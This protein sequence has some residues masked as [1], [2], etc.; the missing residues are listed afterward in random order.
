MLSAK[1][2]R[3]SLLATLWFN[4]AHYAVRPWPWILVARASLILLPGLKDPETGY[5][6]VMIDYLP[7]SLRGLMVAAFAAAFMSTIA[8]QLNWGA[9]YLVNDFYRR[10]VRRDAGEP[11]YVLA[12]RLAT[13]LLTVISAAVAF[14]IESI[15]CAW[16]LLII[17]GAGTGAVLLLRWYWWRINA[18]SEVSAM[19]TAFIVSVLLQTVGR[20]PGQ[21]A[22]LDRRLRARVRGAVRRGQAAV[23]RPTARHPDA[24]PQRHRRGGDLPRPHAARVAHGGRITLPLELGVDERGDHEVRHVGT[25]LEDRRVGAGGMNPVREQD[26]E[27]VLLRIHPQR[28]A[29][30]AR[31]AE[32]ARRQA[33]PRARGRVGRVGGRVPAERARRDRDHALAPREVRDGLG[34]DQ[35]HRVP[36]AAVQ[37]H[38]REA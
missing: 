35:L 14:R 27:Q 37:Q 28:R 15:G 32:R 22:R 25:D 21:P 11:H 30:E 7:S 12:S 16:K 10:F 9:S 38:G 29:G 24:R 1:D 4:I 34:T 2:E 26:D 13:A 17:T 31:V 3:H 33:G 19:I 36:R 23:A 8:T 20:R 6:R 18:W 5:I